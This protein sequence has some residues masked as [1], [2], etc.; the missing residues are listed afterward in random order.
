MDLS[1]GAQFCQF[2][3]FL[4]RICFSIRTCYKELIWS[5]NYQMS[6]FKF[7][8]NGWVLF[9]VAFSLWV[10]LKLILVQ[11]LETIS[12]WMCH[13]SWEQFCYSCMYTKTARNES[14]L[15][16]ETAWV[17]KLLHCWSACKCNDM[18]TWF[19]VLFW[20]MPLHF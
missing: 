9:E 14:Q 20:H 11:P 3:V 12:T 19:S 4:W 5:T 7:S 16:K 1:Q 6:I 8:E 10:S 17:V 2:L 13:V 15:F 18:Q